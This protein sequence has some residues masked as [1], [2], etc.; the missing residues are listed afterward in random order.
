[1]GLF[2]YDNSFAAPLVSLPLFILKYQGNLAPAFTVSNAPIDR[3][4]FVHR[5]MIDATYP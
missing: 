5:Q 4:T 2:G 1:M 3:I